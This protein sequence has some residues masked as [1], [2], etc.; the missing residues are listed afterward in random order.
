MV[1]H[2]TRDYY[3]GMYDFAVSGGAIGSIDLVIPIPA[4]SLVIEFGV[5]TV[6]T[7][8]GGGGAT[9]SFDI[10]N[11]TVNP[12]TTTVGGFRAATVLAGNFDGPN[13]IKAG[14]P[15][16]IATAI[17]IAN[18]CSIGMSIAVAA[19]TAGKVI[20]YAKAISFDF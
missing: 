18:N 14:I 8:N 15:Q 3:A 16:T 1:I 9:I 13:L 10:I 6:T 12:A 11:T 4:N 17:F 2:R 5:R 20:V 19:L 7:F